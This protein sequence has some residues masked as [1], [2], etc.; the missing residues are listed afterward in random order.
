MPAVH[1]F[2]V[3]PSFAPGG[4]Q[5]RICQ[6][7]NHLSGRFRHTVVALDNDFSARSRLDPSVDIREVRCSRSKNPL[8]M[9]RRLRALM[10]RHQP[11][12]V[13][14]YN[15]G[16]IEGS[17]AALM[18]PRIPTIHTEDG[19]GNDEAVRQ[20]TRRVMMRRL[21]L[22]HVSRVVAPSRVLLDIMRGQWGLPESKTLY[23]ANGIDTEL[24]RP[25]ERVPARKGAVV[26][27]TAAR[28]RPEKR[29]DVLL[30][31]IAQVSREHNV[32]LDVAGDGPEREPLQRIANDLGIADRVR[33]LGNVENMPEF[34][35]GL[36]VFALTSSTEQMPYA[37]LEAMASA[38]PVVSTAVGDIKAMVADANVPLIG[39]EEQL[40]Q[41]LTHLLDNAELRLDIGLSNRTL[42][43]ER[44]SL[45]PM[46]QVYETLY[47]GASTRT[48]SN[49]NCTLS[50]SSYRAST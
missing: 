20:K 45:H 7:M 4:V 12:L 23:I 3:I 24:F 28:L 50:T 33:F 22:P 39:R 14:T 1:L 43:Q 17:L 32:R 10:N 35:R 38:L 19:F 49:T 8:L 48:P 21:V 2:H 37:V 29:L 15:W 31:V 16:A 36:D 30:H 34:Y 27:G 41:L 18:P 40:P 46:L 5:V 47:T 13:L 6:I 9:A 11:D 26:V 42:C 25:A 44:Y